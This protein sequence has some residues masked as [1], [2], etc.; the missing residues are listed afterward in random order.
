MEIRR[1]RYDDPVVVGLVE[2]LQEYYTRQYGGPDETELPEGV[3]DDP[4]GAFFVGFLDGF[5]VAM[6]GWRRRDDVAA[7]GGTV[8][9]EIKR[10]HVVPAR[11]RRG[12]ARVMLRHLED[13]AAAAGAD[14]MV[15]ETGM[16]QPEAVALYLSAGY[17]RLS[18]GFG[19][20]AWS[21]LVRYFGKR[22]S[23]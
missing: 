1:V 2:T 17:E 3:F 12:L 10:M 19:H 11:Q 15:L 20:Y 23:R 14:V 5:P 22:L 9:A 6:G 4:S 8:A 18:E 7:L 21:P 16:R 13:T